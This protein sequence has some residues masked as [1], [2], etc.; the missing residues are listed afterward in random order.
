[1]AF[2]RVLE[3][4]PDLASDIEG[5]R[6]EGAVRACLAKLVSL[7]AG[8]WDGGSEP[9]VS[10]FGLLVLAGTLCRRVGQ[11]RYRGAELI[12]PGDLLRPWDRVGEWA[13]IPTGAEFTVIETTRLA[14]LGGEFARRA[15]P[16]PEIASALISRTL[17]RSRYLAIVAA[18]VSQPKVET[19]LHLLFW[20]L[21]DRF[22]RID[23]DSVTV[24][25]PLTHALLAE[26]VAARRPTVSKALSNLAES[27]VLHRRGSEWSL[28]R[29]ASSAY[30]TNGA[31]PASALLCADDVEAAGPIA[32]EPFAQ[33]GI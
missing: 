20:H 32:P 31:T 14:V 6:R 25:L 27:G 12:G 21:A 26:L 13:S 33:S 30:H 19:R 7:P 16:Y 29:R 10:G 22:G 2:A 18:I 8:D 23:R 11:G 17:M 5:H 15:A 3:L 9:E 4:D 1:M 28:K 24:S